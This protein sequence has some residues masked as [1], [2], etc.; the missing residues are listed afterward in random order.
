MRR[1]Q[2]VAGKKNP[3]SAFTS[4]SSAQP[5]L[6]AAHLKFQP[7]QPQGSGNAKRAS[8]QEFDSS[9]WIKS[10]ES[11]SSTL[12]CKQARSLEGGEMGRRRWQC[13]QDNRQ[14]LR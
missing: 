6:I 11:R 12:P 14:G 3:T 5:A 4:H 9:S 7:H 8:N 2:D 13:Q 1:K 10:S